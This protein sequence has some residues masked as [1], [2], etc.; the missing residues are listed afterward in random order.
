VRF[1]AIVACLFASLLVPS[2][3]ETCAIYTVTV[4]VEDLTSGELLC[5]AKVTLFVGDGGGTVTIDASVAPSDA[6]V[7]SSS[8][9]CQWD[10]IVGGG[11]VNITATAPG[12]TAGTT[13]VQLPSDECGNNVAA[14]TVYLSRS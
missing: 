6:E 14:V 12:F 3:A 1:V 9:V 4:V 13:A 8:S 10:T 5:D 11:N 2:C 7:A